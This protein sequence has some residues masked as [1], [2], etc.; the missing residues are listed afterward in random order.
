MT[1]NNYYCITGT[2][3]GQVV[4][5]GFIQIRLPPIYRRLLTRLVAIVPAVIATSVGGDGAVDTL[6]IFSQVIL[7]FALPFAM[8]PLI[9]LTSDKSKMHTH[10]NSM[11]T[12]VIAWILF[13]IISGL[14]AYLIFASFL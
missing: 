14:N 9:Y 5:E 1:H 10:V 12:T 11:L 7:S 4:M 6:L 2:F 8:F 3:A 13:V